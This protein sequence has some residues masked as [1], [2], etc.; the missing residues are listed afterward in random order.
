MTQFVRVVCVVWLIGAGSF[1]VIVKPLA[2][3]QDTINE[4]ARSAIE[5]NS[6][7][8]QTLRDQ[9]LDARIATLEDTILEVKWLGRTAA[10]ILLGQLFLGILSS[11]KKAP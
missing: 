3:T 6:N 2:Q 5:N 11:R 1:F 4:R 8:I 10:T 7:E 9:N